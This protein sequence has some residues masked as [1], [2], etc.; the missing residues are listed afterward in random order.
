[1]KYSFL[2]ALYL[3][4]LKK[5]NG[6]NVR[7]EILDHQINFFF[8]RAEWNKTLKSISAESMTSELEI[9][10]SFLGYRITR[11]EIKLDKCQIEVLR[12]FLRS[13]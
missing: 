4:F 11:N 13:R 7:N 6:T 10:Q 1:M 5:N 9:N 3:F 2:R 8:V 12:Q